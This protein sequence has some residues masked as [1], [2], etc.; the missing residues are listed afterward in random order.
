M[1]EETK[2]PLRFRRSLENRLADFD[3]IGRRLQAERSAAVELIDQALRSTP[4]DQWR[5]LAERPALQTSGALDRIAALIDQEITRNPKL[6]EKLAMLGLSIAEAIPETA[7][8]PI[9][10][11][12]IHSFAWKDHGK[13]LSYLARHE[14]A[15]RS[16]DNAEAAFNVFQQG[17]AH[18]D[19]AIINLNRAITFS[20]MGR[21]QKALDYLSVCKEVFRGH[22]DT[23]LFIL[24][25]FYEGHA[26]KRLGNYRDAREI[27]LLLIASGESI[28][29]S[30][31]GALY[32]AIGVCST[33]LKDY[34][35]AEFYISKSIT[36]LSDLGQTA[37]V[38]KAEY[39][40]GRLLLQRGRTAEA[41][42]HLRTVRHRFLMFSLAEEAG[43]S[44]LDMVHGMLSLGRGKDAERLARTIL[45]EFLA[46]GLNER[47]IT[48]LGYLA[49]AIETKKATPRTASRIREYILSLRTEPER[50]FEQHD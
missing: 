42:D 23:R 4:A 36:V 32:Q 8:P 26:L 45:S 18:H 22:G 5:V 28:D 48:A 17:I 50:E 11:A 38:V 44:G 21:Y 33:E 7:Y 20:E 27:Y 13:V 24:S 41:I 10:M 14:D 31:L 40:R 6:A 35:T 30:T 39:S 25:N 16:F 29:K 47:T 49:E 15:L 2:P 34:D 43:L 46:A 9:V 3:A 12:Q 19:L 1:P 37:D